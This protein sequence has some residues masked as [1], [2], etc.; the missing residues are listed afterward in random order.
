MHAYI[1]TYIRYIHIFLHF[2][3]NYVLIYLHIKRADT[4]KI[5]GV[6]SRPGQ[7]NSW[8]FG[9]GYCLATSWACFGLT[10]AETSP[11]VVKK[12]PVVAGMR[13]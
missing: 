5:L 10:K 2:C 11:E 6:S 8:G 4:R 1:H 9:L 7:G 13:V 12:A 3:V